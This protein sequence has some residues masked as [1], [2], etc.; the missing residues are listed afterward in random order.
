MKKTKRYFYTGL[1][2]L[3]PLLLTM[4]IFSWLFK[5]ALRIVK[6]TFITKIISTILT[7]I[8]GMNTNKLQFTII[9]YVVSVFIMLTFIWL[10]G[11][12]AR[13]VIVNK[14]LAGVKHLFVRLPIIKHI[15][16]TINQIVELLSKDNTAMYKR[17]VTVEYPRDGIFSI[18]FVTADNNIAIEKALNKKDMCNVFIPTAPNPTSGMLICV[19]KD[20]IKS[21]D[22][23]VEEAFK[24]II[25]GGFI[26][27]SEI[28]QNIE[29][30]L[31]KK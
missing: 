15:Y 13:L 28:D 10:V 12:T 8:Y 26:T 31:E 21:L 16:N 22:I 11:F 14:I 4:S 20:K 23:S 1:I 17:V 18:G 9:S 27:S 3:L 19:S 29:E 2:S 6:E 7:L 24:L 30:I 5:I 25:S